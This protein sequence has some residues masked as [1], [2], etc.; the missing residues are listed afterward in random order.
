MIKEVIELLKATPYEDGGELIQRA[1]GKYRLPKTLKE[2]WRTAK[3]MSDG[4][5]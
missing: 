5:R 1:K 3:R 4:R 2:M